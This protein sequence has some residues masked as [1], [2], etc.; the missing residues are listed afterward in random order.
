MT[1]SA[2]RG[3]IWP[4]NSRP[5]EEADE[6]YR[7]IRKMLKSFQLTASRGGRLIMTGG[8]A[9]GNSFNSRPHEEADDNLV[10]NTQDMVIFQLTASRGGRRHT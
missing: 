6:E 1:G 10:D 9:S 2:S 8:D 7:A 3:C 4:F 5:H